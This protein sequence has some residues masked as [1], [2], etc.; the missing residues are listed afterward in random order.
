MSYFI[1]V[2]GT[3]ID[4]KNKQPIAG[5]LEFIDN[6]NESKTSYLV[7]TNNTKQKSEEFY[8]FLTNLGFN[9]PKNCYLD[10]F[11]VL[12]KSLHVKRVC[13]FGPQEFIDVVESLGYVNT[14]ENPEAILVTSSKD[15]HSEDY[16]LMIEKV[17]DGAQLIGMHATSTYAKQGKRYPGVGAIMEML[18][19]ATGCT[20]T[21]IGKPSK[22]FY[23]EGLKLLNLTSF[24]E[25]EMISDDAVGDLCG[26]KS[27]GAKTTLVLSGKCKSEKEALHVKTSIDKIVPN[28]GCING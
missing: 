19:Y 10:P 28:I 1:D 4:D 17:M 16:A 15:F 20:Y 13:C 22:A 9:I 23:E 14:K 5:A 11:M 27:L 12:K 6:L 18:S 2:Q 3:L 25:I 21:V 7:V 24:E 8:T 26:I